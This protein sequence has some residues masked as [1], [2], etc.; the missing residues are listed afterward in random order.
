LA[1]AADPAVAAAQFHTRW[2]EGWLESNAQ[3]LAAE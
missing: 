2:L 3:K 1:L